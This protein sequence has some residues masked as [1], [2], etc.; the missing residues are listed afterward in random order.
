MATAG[1][2]KLT[3]YAMVSTSLSA[4]ADRLCVVDDPGDAPSG[5]ATGN[6]LR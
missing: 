6:T 2:L 3:V 4:S 1:L 5:Q